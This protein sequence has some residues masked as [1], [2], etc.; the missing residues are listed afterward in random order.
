MKKKWEN[1]STN[2]IL[3]LMCVFGCLELLVVEVIVT[4]DLEVPPNPYPTFPVINVNQIVNMSRHRRA[5]T[6]T[7]RFVCDSDRS[8]L[9]DDES[10]SG[11]FE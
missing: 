1:N 4:V 2:S 9:M 7:F 3:D 8:S 5:R 11:R 6:S 10:M